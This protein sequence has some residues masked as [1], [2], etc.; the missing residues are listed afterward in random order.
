MTYKI[1]KKTTSKCLHEIFVA[2]RNTLT[3]KINPPQRLH[4]DMEPINESTCF[5]FKICLLPSNKRQRVIY[6]AYFN[7]AEDIIIP[8]QQETV[9]LRFSHCKADSIVYTW[10]HPQHPS[11]LLF[12]T[13]YNSLYSFCKTSFFLWPVT[14][15]G[16]MLQM[17][18]KEWAD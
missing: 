9:L 13:P 17:V 2:L 10:M 5:I 18:K 14:K 4:S 11:S 16:I 3:Y 7:M 8:K 6:F 15:Y 12:T 1:Q